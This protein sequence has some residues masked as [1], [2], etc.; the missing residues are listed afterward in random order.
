[1]QFYD[2]K[3]ADHFFIQ[4]KY[5]FRYMLKK[6]SNF[7]YILP[8]IFAHLSPKTHISL[9]SKIF[10][11]KERDFKTHKALIRL[12]HASAFY[13]EYSSKFLNSFYYRKLS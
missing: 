5:F 9:G 3:E 10:S 13:N 1:M 4:S 6:N 11:K 2:F 12:L 7:V 8:S